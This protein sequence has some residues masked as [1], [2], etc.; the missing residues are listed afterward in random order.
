MRTEEKT[1]VVQSVLLA[2]DQT[3]DDGYL[4][5]VRHALQCLAGGPSPW[6]SQVRTV[7]TETRAEHLR[8]DGYVGLSGDGTQAFVQQGHVGLR[9][10]PH[11]RILEKRYAHL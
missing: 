4:V 6:F 5:V 3:A 1:S 10:R 2:D 11:D 8:Y 9:V 7:G